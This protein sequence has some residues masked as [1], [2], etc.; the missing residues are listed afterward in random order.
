MVKTANYKF[1]Y[2]TSQVDEILNVV[3][4]DDDKKERE[5]FK[6]L[7]AGLTTEAIAKEFKI[8]SRTVER[9]RNDIHHKILS[10]YIN[11]APNE[12][13]CLKYQYDSNADIDASVLCEVEEY[14]QHLWLSARI[15]SVYVLVFPNNK[16]Y[17]GQ[18]KDVS[19]RWANNGGHYC[20][21]EQMFL[22]ITKYG[23]DSIKKFEVYK[24]LTYAESICKERELIKYYKTLDERYGYNRRM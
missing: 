9:R 17:V 16:L 1:E 5:I 10:Q 15:Y 8:C 12:D 7:V 3:A 13:L 20:E 2:S 14:R 24:N 6:K 19:S 18:T 21:N 11:K 23:W 4:F 22:D